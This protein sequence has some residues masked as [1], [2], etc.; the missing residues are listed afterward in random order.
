MTAPIHAMM[1]RMP[2]LD[3]DALEQSIARQE[4]ETA[5]IQ[6]RTRSELKLEAAEANAAS[7]K[8]EGESTRI[9]MRRLRTNIEK[10]EGIYGEMKRNEED[11]A[12]ELAAELAAIDKLRTSGV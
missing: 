12:V 5:G 3:Q 1:L 9:A 10:L 4:E 7:L 11:I 2:V 6:I 8:I